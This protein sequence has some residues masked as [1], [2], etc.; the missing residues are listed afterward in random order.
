MDN[1]WVCV[2][3]AHIRRSYGYGSVPYGLQELGRYPS[4]EYSFATALGFTIYHESEC[5]DYEA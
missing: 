1:A 5:P 4:M 2:A 3:F